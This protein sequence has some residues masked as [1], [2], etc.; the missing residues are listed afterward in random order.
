MKYFSIIAFLIFTAFLQQGRAQ[1]SA[2]ATYRVVGYYK[3]DLLE[4]AEKVDFS[5]IT[6]LNVAFVNP[7]SNGVFPVVPGLTALVS[8]AHEHHVKIFAAI[9]GGKAPKYYK[10]LISPVKSDLFVVNIRNLMDNYALDGIDVDIEGPLITSAYEGFIIKLAAVIKP[11]G[12]LTAAF[13]TEN[14]TNITANT[15]AQ[16]DFIN[17]MSYDKTGPWRP[18][19][20]GPHSPYEMAEADLNFWKAKGATKEQLNL[21]VPFYGYAFNA[22]LTSLSYKRLLE[23][24]PGAEKIDQLNLNG[25]GTVYYNGIP[26]IQKKTLLALK[27]AGGI[28]IWQLAQDAPGKKSLLTT[29]DTV[30]KNFNNTQRVKK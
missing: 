14:A 23:D 8:K 2:T 12:L 26:T 18:A 22:K 10:E 28:M 24:Y 6:H 1:S 13:A 16:F 25:G 15:I 4:A 17:I 29:I 20:S 27:E 7:D 9:G 3:G 11:Q 19:D 21:G 5:K 30:I